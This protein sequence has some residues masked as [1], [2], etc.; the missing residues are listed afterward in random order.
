M[1]SRLWRYLSF[2]SATRSHILTVGYCGLEAKVLH[3]SVISPASINIYWL[4]LSFSKGFPQAFVMIKTY[5]V[6][7]HPSK[8]WFSKYLICYCEICSLSHV[9]LFVIQH[10]GPQKWPINKKTAYYSI[11]CGTEGGMTLIAGGPW[12]NTIISLGYEVIWGFLVWEW[13]TFLVRS[14]SGH[15]PPGSTSWRGLSTSASSACLCTAHFC[16]IYRHAP[17]FRCTG[18][19]SP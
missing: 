4:Y 12:V 8:T 1:A 15:Q 5:Q 19:S 10:S 2:L 18:A 11:K 17:R 9:G 16:L 6:G 3:W 7:W 13:L 14:S